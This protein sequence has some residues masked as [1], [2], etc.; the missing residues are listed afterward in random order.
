VGS[1]A[2]G[3][4]TGAYK[5]WRRHA[6]GRREQH[7]HC[8]FRS[9]QRNRGLTKAAQDADIIR[10]THTVEYDSKRGDIDGDND[11]SAGQHSD[12]AAL[13]FDQTTTGTYSGVM[14]RTGSMQRV[15]LEM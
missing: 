14:E 7:E 9:A 8:I 3:G 5:T 6:Y 13:I 12:N 4:A 11:E 1:I 15:D 2:G 10:A